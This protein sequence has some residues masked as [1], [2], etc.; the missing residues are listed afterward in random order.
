M[1]KYNSTRSNIN[2]APSEAILKGISSDGG[3]FVPESFPKIDIDSLLG[4]SYEEICYEVL[5]K[6]FYEFDESDLKHMISQAY[7]KFNTKDV[8]PVAALGEL[9][10]L[11]LYHGPTLAFKDV[12][13]SI[14]P[15]L[16]TA[17]A[18]IQ[19]VD[20]EIVILTATSGDT[21]KA[22][23][24]GFADVQ[25]TSIIV[26]Y[27]NDGVSMIQRKQMT[28]QVGKNV[29]VIAIEGNFDDAQKGV[30]E[31]FNDRGYNSLLK[32]NGYV[33]SSANSI[34]IGRLVPQIVYYFDSY[35]KSVASGKIK[36]GDPIN[37]TVPTGNFGNILA[38]Y[39][40]KNMGLPVN[41][42]ICASNDNNVLFDFFSTG[43]YDKNRPFIKTI[44]P[45][46]DI[47]VS[48]N[49]ERL[50][51]HVSN[52]DK[53]FVKNS[54]NELSTSGKYSV[55][56][57]IKEIISDN[58]YG[59]YCNEKETLET[60]KDVYEKYG[61]V[62]DP[63]TAVGC[64]V[65][66]DYKTESNDDTYNIIL[67]TASPYKFTKSVYEAIFGPSELDDY[68]LIEK[69]S[70]GTGLALPKELITMC[71]SDD[72]HKKVYASN[73]MKDSISEILL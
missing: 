27:P 67:S 50:L 43:E 4:K 29:H 71:N 23:L 66:A 3:L 51:C 32:E 16:L 69:L 10:F 38:G 68:T 64:K 60:I 31:I 61:Y 30:K 7:G 55:S 11:E 35:I 41:K 72:I 21:G 26:F 28:T 1:I 39:Y 20:D 5:S 53:E 45:S 19:N 22:A 42:L 52:F 14:L 2:V 17:S 40:A 15:H 48:S 46:M 59:N 34:N 6:Y 47:L 37:F 65:Y 49:F 25:G 9:N 56:K 44:S 36:M 33:L 13:L 62:I 54:M 63:H 70:K 73:K 57:E 58:F 18:K 8:T 24:E 12:A